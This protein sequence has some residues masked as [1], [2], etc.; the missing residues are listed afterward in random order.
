MNLRMSEGLQLKSHGFLSKAGWLGRRPL[1]P[2]EH[3]PDAQAKSVEIAG[4][5]PSWLWI[6]RYSDKFTKR[7]GHVCISRWKGAFPRRNAISCSRSL[8]DWDAARVFLEVVR[9][10]S[11]R[12]AAERLEL[13]INASAG[14]STDF[15]RQIAPPCSRATSMHPPDGGGSLVVSAVERMEAVVRPAAAPAVRSPTPSP[16]R[17][18]SHHEGLGTFGWPRALSIPASSRYL[19]ASTVRCARATCRGMKP[20]LRSICRGGRA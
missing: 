5:D 10:G 3:R 7:K 4:R 17:S 12:S 14:A 16:E 18:G 1:A 20:T 15:E 11:F 8:T 6:A 19:V 9:C 13:S 2:P